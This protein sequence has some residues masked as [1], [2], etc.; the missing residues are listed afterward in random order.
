MSFHSYI[1]QNPPNLGRVFFGN[2]IPISPDGNTYVLNDQI[3]FLPVPST[4]QIVP[5]GTPYGWIC[6]AGGAGGTATWVPIG[7]G[8]GLAPLTETGA[9]NAIV[10][11][12][13]PVLYVGLTVSVLLA[14]TLQN[15]ANTFAYNGGAAVAIKSHFNVANNIGTAYAVGSVVTLLWDGTEWQDTSQ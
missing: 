8:Y 11:A 9:N 4:S 6:T 3:I 15:G 1:T 12:G 2:S 14:H 5:P 13:G 10:A 7:S